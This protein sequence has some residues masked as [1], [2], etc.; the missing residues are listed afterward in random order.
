MTKVTALMLPGTGFSQGG[1]GVT[2]AFLHALD[3]ARF[4]TRIVSYPAEFGGR[5]PWARSRDIGKQ[6]LIDALYRTEGRV[7]IGGFSQGA[8][9]AGALAAEIGRGDHPDLKPWV[10]AAALIADPERP[11]GGSFGEELAAPGYGIAGAR[12]VHGLRTF[13]AA[14]DRDPITSLPKGSPLRALPDVL[15]FYS[16]ASPAAAWAWGQALVERARERRFQRWWDLRNIHQW[17]GAAEQMRNYLPGPVGGG[18]HGAAYV[19]EG[20][21]VRLAGHINWTVR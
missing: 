3:P 8:G 7:I 16:L 18:R 10:L 9:I 14:A 2:E 13:W 20:L 1:D 21:C 19:A 6:A 12:E 5:M 15:D 4:D 11:P 17:G